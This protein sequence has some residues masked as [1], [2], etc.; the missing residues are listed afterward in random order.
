MKY[1]V[2]LFSFLGILVIIGCE[3][4]KESINIKEEI[5]AV[6][7]VLEKYVIA[8]E[9]KDF[10]LIAQIWAE[11][12]NIILL[13]T[14]SH[15][16]YIGWKQ[17][18]K[19]IQKQFKEFQDTYISITDQKINVNESGNTAWFSQ[20][21]NYNFIYRDEAMSFE[22]IRFTGVLEKREDNWVLVQGHLSIPA[23]TGA[24]TH[25]N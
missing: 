3:Q 13:G 19:A 10:S 11:D 16:K 1:T 18:K 15:E 9:N 23:L 24:E 8:N 4:K 21:L 22:G 2:L 7:N 5:T 12:E 20:F 14:D 25:S 17:I 6:E